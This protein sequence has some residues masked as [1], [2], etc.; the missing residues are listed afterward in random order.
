MITQIMHPWL[1]KSHLRA[2]SLVTGII[3]QS[4]G[5]LNGQVEIEAICEFVARVHP[6]FGKQFRTLGYVLIIL[7]LINYIFES[8]LNCGMHY[9]FGLQTL[10]WY[11]LHRPHLFMICFACGATTF[12]CLVF[13]GSILMVFGIA[14]GSLYIVVSMSQRTA[15]IAL[16]CSF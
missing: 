6:A 10:H 3:L 5:G 14:F 9:L 13:Y 16:C 12:S 8:L 1:A 11:A 15:L 4:D 7:A 2:G